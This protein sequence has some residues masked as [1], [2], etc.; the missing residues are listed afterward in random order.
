MRVTTFKVVREK[1]S[2]ISTIGDMY[3]DG[4]WYFTT[5]EDPDRQ[6]QPDG[7][8]TPWSAKIKIPDETAIPYGT[9]RLIINHSDKYKRTMPLVLNV[10][11][12]NGIRI[13]ILNWARESKGCIGVGKTK[14]KDMI[15]RSATAFK[16][17]FDL[18]Y[19]ALSNDGYARLIITNK[20][21]EAQNENI[22]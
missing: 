8:I 2:N 5:L 13:H 15:G 1:Y 21:L 17:F 19:D 18:L 10:P 20:E 16:E 3:I 14:G 7:T 9:Y 12:F 4:K 22:L 6:R 11:D